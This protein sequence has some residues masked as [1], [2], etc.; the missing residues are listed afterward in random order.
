MKQI[1]RA[2]WKN[3]EWT[4]PDVRPDRTYRILIG[5]HHRRCATSSGVSGSVEILDLP[6]VE[7]PS[8][9]GRLLCSEDVYRASVR[10]LDPL[11]TVE[12]EVGSDR[13]FRSRA[14][15]PDNIASWSTHTR[16]SRVGSLV[17]ARAGS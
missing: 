11:L 15:R 8:I 5:P 17:L 1:R 7:A 9:E 2:D 16:R 4:F 10:L 14:S 12:V 3:G 13:R 6:S